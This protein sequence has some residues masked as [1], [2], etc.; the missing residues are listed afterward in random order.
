MEN[1]REE[2][3]NLCNNST[4]YERHDDFAPLNRNKPG[5]G[6]EKGFQNA[7]LPS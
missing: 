7:F 2:L 6:L 5:N 4:T 1:M 3:G